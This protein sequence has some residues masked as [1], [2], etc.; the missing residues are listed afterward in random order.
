MSI[1]N[2]SPKGQI[3]IPANLRKKYNI[4]PHDRLEILEVDNAIVL[5]PLA[6]DPIQ[7]ARGF[8]KFRRSSK[9]VMTELKQELKKYKEEY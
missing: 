3:V 9:E 1:A 5:V 8:L 4:G 7:S 2:V 6:K